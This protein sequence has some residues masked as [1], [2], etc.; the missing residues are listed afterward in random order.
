MKRFSAKV[1]SAIMVM[2]MALSM[3]SPTVFAADDEEVNAVIKQLEEI[4]TLQQMQDKRKSFSV[5]QSTDRTTTDL[6]VLQAH[7]NARIGYET[8]VAE[9]FAAR[10]AAQQ[11]YDALTPDQK[12][13]I[14]A[15]LV[16]KLNNELDT[17]F[18][19]GTYKVT[20]SNNEY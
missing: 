7:E 14:D 13:Q 11:A 10:I 3:V 8:Y 12:A 5:N 17:V 6:D 9:M 18:H 4:D 20:P 2:L 19:S 16:A 15:S 1:L